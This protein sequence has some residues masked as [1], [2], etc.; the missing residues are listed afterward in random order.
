MYVG[1]NFSS[2]NCFSETKA[3]RPLNEFRYQHAVKRYSYFLAVTNNI[4][5]IIADVAVCRQGGANSKKNHRY[6]FTS[7]S[8]SLSAPSRQLIRLPLALFTRTQSDPAS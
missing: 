3:L 7:F 2:S 6:A 8:A 4:I 5:D 1:D